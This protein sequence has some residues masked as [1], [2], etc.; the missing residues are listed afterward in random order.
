[1]GPPGMGGPGGPG[2]AN[3]EILDWVRENGKLVDSALWQNPPKS[4][5]EVP[6]PFGPMGGGPMGRGAMGMGRQLYDLKPG[7][8][9]IDPSLKAPGQNP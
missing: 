1:M 2:S 3:R 8:G 5:E 7:K 4:S 9:L 6:F